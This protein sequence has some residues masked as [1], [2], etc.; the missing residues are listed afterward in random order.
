MDRQQN[1]LFTQEKD[2][3]LHLKSC[4][5]V[6]FSDGFLLGRS[7]PSSIGGG[8][9]VTDQHGKVLERKIIYSKN[10]TNNEAELL[11]L[12][13]AIEL[14]SLYDEIVVDSNTIISWIKK[15]RSKA[16][17]D[18]NHLLSTG[19]ELSLK[20][21]LYIYWR[22]RD[23]NKAGVYNEEHHHNATHNN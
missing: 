21:K 11:G 2:Q 17:K 20:K 14:A 23:E 5:N 4:S 6:L 7:N 13:C 10:F 8:Y 15:G 9:T 19:K 12:L 16:R 3:S 22:P 1:N 18:L